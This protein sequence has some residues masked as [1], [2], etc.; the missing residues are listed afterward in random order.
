[1]G[2]AAKPRLI[3]LDGMRGIAAVLVVL[4][5]GARAFRGSP[6]F[7]RGY[8]AVDFFFLLSGFVLAGAFEARMRSGSLKP[9]SFLFRRWARLWPMA[10]LGAVLGAISVV[11]GIDD[12]REAILPLLAALALVPDLA[13]AAPLFPVDGP[14]WSMLFELIANLF[15][16]A[17]LARVRDETLLLFVGLL[18]ASCALAVAHFGTIDF[19]HQGRSFAYGFLR[20]GFSYS[21]G[22]FLSRKFDS[23]PKRTS[24]A[25]L[26]CLLVL[27]AS[28]IAVAVLPLATGAGN[29]LLVMG[30]F[31]ALVWFAARGSSPGW[32]APVLEFMGA[33]SFPL[34]A[35]HVPILSLI[36]F[37]V[38]PLPTGSTWTIQL[39]GLAASLAAAST[40]SR[41]RLA[42]GL[43]LPVGTTGGASLAAAAA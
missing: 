18:G 4:H 8:L 41:T 30:V 24:C 9:L 7:A 35:V 23:L 21:L 16:G 13:G 20:V 29:L 42:R 15:H 43:A 26:L 34:Y 25:G 19:G 12:W 40:L 3:L 36:R 32:S 1:M 31:P 11:P 17:A 2:G 10:A 28:I 38:W 37:L 22:V 27:P 39:A 6:L 33:V 5:H 14:L